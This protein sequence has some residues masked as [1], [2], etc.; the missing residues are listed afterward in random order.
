[1]HIIYRNTISFTAALADNISGKVRELD[2][3]KVSLIIIYLLVAT[4]SHHLESCGCLFTTS[5]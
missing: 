1:M 3:T 5:K 2:V 4:N